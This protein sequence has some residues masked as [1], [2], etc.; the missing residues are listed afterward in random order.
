MTLSN[1]GRHVER[2]AQRR[3]T[4]FGNMGCFVDR[5][6]RDM[7]TRIETREGDQL[8]HVAKVGNGA[9]FS[10]EF[11]S[12]QVANTGNRGQ[13]VTLVLEGGMLVNMVG[14]GL[15]GL[16]DLRLQQGALSWRISS[17]RGAQASGCWVRQKSAMR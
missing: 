17:G 2:G 8:T 4:R 11:A 12:G 10:Q 15:L 16:C 13:Q 6:T 14:N 7:L 5:G 3:A 9:E 1:N